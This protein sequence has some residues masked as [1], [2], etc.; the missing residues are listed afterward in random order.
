MMEKD[1]AFGSDFFD[2]EKVSSILIKRVAAFREGCHQNIGLIG[3][4]HIGKSSILQNFILATNYPDIIP[5]YVE[6]YGEAFPD[7]VKRFMGMMLIGYYQSAGKAVPPAVEEMIKGVRREL[8]CTTK[9]M[10]R[11]LQ[12]VKKN[13][14]NEAFYELFS[15]C[16]SLA[17]EA[18]KKIVVVIDEFSLFDQFELNDPFSTFGKQIMIQKN[19]MFIVAC[20]SIKYG[21]E[22]FNEKLTLL[23]GNFEVI[24]V[25]PFDFTTTRNMISS[26]LAPLAIPGNLVRFLTRLTDGNPYYLTILLNKLRSVALRNDQDVISEQLLINA[27]ETEMFFADGRLAHHINSLFTTLFQTKRYYYL[28]VLV[29]IALGHKKTKDIAHFLQM[30]LEEAKKLLAHLMNDEIVLKNGSFF[31]IDDPLLCFW[32]TH[33]Y[34]LRRNSLKINKVLLNTQF[35]TLA[36]HSIAAFGDDRD[37]DIIKRVEDLFMNFKNDAIVLGGKKR[38][39]PAFTNVASEIAE[40]KITLT[41]KSSSNRWMCEIVLKEATEDDVQFFLDK[42]KHYKA[43]VNKKIMIIPYDIEMNAKLLAKEARICLWGLRDI[44]YLFDLYNIPKFIVEKDVSKITK[45]DYAE[46]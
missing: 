3:K 10:S 31:F 28:N 9:N 41:A 46:V 40:D 6:V 4:K 23:F 7:F 8:P 30:R 42:M 39:Y 15:L 24:E 44:N 11:I 32:L 5:V 29:A 34:N 12:L 2:R 45:G 27:L 16:S 26:K 35:R 14:H 18:G 20:S 22:I 37:Q 25:K 36:A 13:K 43:K 21:Y 1:P 33:V 17:A 38:K 19:T